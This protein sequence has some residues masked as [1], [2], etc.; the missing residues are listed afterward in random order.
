VPQI[1]Q[2]KV[3]RQSTIE[4]KSIISGENFPYPENLGHVQ[5][6]WTAKFKNQFS[7]LTHKIGTKI[8]DKKAY[9]IYG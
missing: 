3:N 1:C 8:F 5:S 7:L 4:I 9:F 2:L 6:L